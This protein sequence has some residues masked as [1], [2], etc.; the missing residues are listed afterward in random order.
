MLEEI[1]SNWPG[2]LEACKMPIWAGWNRFVLSQKPS[3][4][5]AMS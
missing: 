4:Q 3:S 2:L 1:M 5:D